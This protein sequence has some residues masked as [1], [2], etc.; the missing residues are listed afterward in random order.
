MGGTAGDDMNFQSLSHWKVIS[1]VTG[2]FILS[3]IEGSCRRNT[4]SERKER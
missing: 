4:F 1:S 3:G 2:I